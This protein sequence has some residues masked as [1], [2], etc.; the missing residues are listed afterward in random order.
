MDQ[1]WNNKRS[2]VELH[3]LV[4]F[5]FFINDLDAGVDSLLIKFAGGT[6]LVEVI[7]PLE[8]KVRTQKGLE[9][10]AIADKMKL[11]KDV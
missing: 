8:A 7:I 5:D 2:Q 9:N 6:K 3:C 4:L 10:W 1:C 11:N